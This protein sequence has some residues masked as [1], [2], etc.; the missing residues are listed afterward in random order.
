VAASFQGSLRLPEPA[1]R[2][3]LILHL[4]QY[5][6]FLETVAGIPCTRSS[7]VIWIAP[8]DGSC[9]VPGQTPAD[10]LRIFLRLRGCSQKSAAAVLHF[11]KEEAPTLDVVRTIISSNVV[12]P[13]IRRC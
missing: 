4:N 9:T 12:V 13:G 3:S 7:A 2:A 5:S 8:R 1:L 10:E 6:A 11:Y